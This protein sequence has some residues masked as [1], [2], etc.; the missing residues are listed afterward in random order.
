MYYPGSIVSPDLVR[1][2]IFPQNDQEGASSSCYFLQENNILTLTRN[3]ELSQ[4]ITRQHCIGESV[5]AGNKA[6]QTLA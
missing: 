2:Y 4:N 1:A 6:E 3:F 5:V